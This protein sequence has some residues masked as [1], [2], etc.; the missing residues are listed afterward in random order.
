MRPSDYAV[1]VIGGGPAGCITA[2]QLVRSGISAL[3]LEASEYGAPRLGE[4]LS[5]HASRYLAQL[6]IA[7]HVDPRIRQ[8]ANGVLSVWGSRKP[9]VTDYWLG[10]HGAG[11]HVDRAAFDR[12]LA[13]TARKA[14]AT[15]CPGSRL[16]S[17]PRR[18]R[19]R[20]VFEFTHNGQRFA[21]SCRFLVDATGRTGTP[22]LGPL[23]PRIV[24]DRLIAVVW[25]GKSR[26]SSPYLSVE[27]VC[28]GWFSSADLPHDQTTIAYMT[29]SDLYRGGCQI[30]SHLW[31]CRLNQTAYA[32]ERLGI[33]ADLSKLRIVSAATVIRA[34]PVGEHWCA[35]GDA[36]FSHD[37]L[38]GLGVHHAL[39]S[40]A[41]AASVIKSF[42]TGNECL[43]SYESWIARS[44]QEYLVSRAQ[45][46]ASEYR[47]RSSP[48]WKR[49][50]SQ[51]FA[52][53]NTSANSSRFASL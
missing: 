22:W 47:W 10:V 14:G 19:K 31:R 39:Q 32:R 17:V 44:V 40:G 26:S 6:G 1:A 30:T 35:V 8:S 46:Y 36:A 15:V 3:L 48:F 34:T 45:H 52:V 12:M 53:T 43:N 38:S 33:G 2:L 37:P 25:T 9:R 41:H 11:W 21:C 16:V 4:T 29:D 23:S 50:T 49:R 51:T 24:H 42:L 7:R 13:E 28:D 18:N 27:S 20:W 5:P